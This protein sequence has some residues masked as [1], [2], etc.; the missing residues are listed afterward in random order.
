MLALVD[1]GLNDSAIERRTGI[2][3]RTIFDWRQGQIPR[4]ARASASASCPRCGHPDHDFLRLPPAYLYL[5]GLYLGDGSIARYPR[6]YR[7]TVSLDRA[8]P[9]IQS[10]CRKAMN[11]VMPTSKVG[12]FHRAP[13][14]TDEVFSYSTAWPCLFPQHGSGKK[15]LRKI[16]LNDWQRD[17]V[18]ADPKPVL[19][20]LIHSDGS[21]H[22]NTIRHPNRTYRYPRYEF[23]NLSQ[24]IKDIFCGCCDVLEIEW[25]VMN[26]K[27]ISVARRASVA[28]LD[29]FIGPKR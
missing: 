24:D 16:E 26:Y 3:R 9:G 13:E 17:L 18:E 10:E 6:T 20:G 11:V 1:E 27:T 22:L 2:P 15:H 12:V 25:T 14:Q 21:R 7:L 4:F 19:R 23:T 28:T 8:Y 5:L 29:Q